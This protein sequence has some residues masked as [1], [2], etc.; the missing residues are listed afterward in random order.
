VIPAT[1]P[2]AV[3]VDTAH[4]V[5]TVRPLRA[6]GTAVDSDPRGK[7]PLL[8]DPAH[9]KLML[10]T[11]L[12]TLTYRL[13]TELSIQDWHWNP[14]GTFSDAA[15]GQGYWTS[16]PDTHAPSITDSF[17][18]TLPHRGDSRDQGDD[19]G[20]SRIDDGDPST[21]WKSNPYLTHRY[22]G[23][24]DSANPQ[25]LAVQ[26]L[27]PREIDAVRIAWSNPY[28]VRYDVQYWTG[29]PDAIL[30]PAAG[31]WHEFARGRISSGSGGTVTLRLANAPVRTTFVRVLMSASSNTCDTHGSGDVRNCLGYAVQDVGVGTI[32]AAGTFHNDVHESRDGSCNGQLICTPDPKRQ[33]LIW[34][35]SDDP[36]HRA[37]DKV[38]GDQDQTGLDL[39]ADSQLTRNLPAIYPVP[40]FY[41]TPQ[42]AANEIRY[43]EARGHKI[44]YVEMGEEV[45]GQYA[46]PEDYGA[47]YVQFAD[48]IHAVDPHVKL[49]GPVFEGVDADVRAWADRQ[50]RTSWLQRFIAY[51]KRRGRF[52][53][54]AFMSWEH[55]PYHHCDSGAQLQHDLLDEPDFV[56]R[57]VQTWRRDAATMPLLE[58]EDNFSPDGTAA[59]QHEY[60]PLWLG[61]FFGASLDSG[62]TY[63]TYYQAEA[64]PLGY[65][66]RCNVWGAY[67][68]Y[69]VDNQFRVRGKAP[70][71]YALR[72]LTTQW[73]QPGDE[74]QGVYPVTTSLGEKNAVLTA[75]ALHRPDGA[76]SLLVDN[77]DFVAHRVSVSIGASGF[78]GDV[79]MVS[80][81]GTKT[82]PA[83]ASY[84]VPAR[85]LT[86]LRGF[87]PVALHVD[88]VHPVQSLRPWD[89][90]GSTV[91]KEP[92]GSIPFLY[93]RA[94]VAQMLDAG[95]GFLSYRLFT[96]LTDED[97]HWNPSGSFSNGTDGYWTSSASPGQSAIAD[98]FGYRLPLTGNTTD[99]GASE[100]YSRLD[101]GD[102]Q[103]YW[104]SN[105]YLSSRF[106]GE[107]DE[108]HPQ[109]AVID[110]GK[111]T[112]V[113]AVRVTWVNPYAVDYDV[114]YWT[115]A[116][117]IGDP[118]HG[119]WRTFTGGSVRSAQG[120]EVTTRLEPTPRSVQFVRVL[121]T[122]SSNTCDTHASTD[123]R[124]CVGYAIGELAVGT[125]D[126]TGFHDV[127][128]H[129]AGNGQTVTYVS[130]VDPWHRASDRVRNQEQPGLDLIAQSGLTRNIGAF[131]PIPLWYSTPQNAANE[132]RYLRA[133]HYPIAGIEMGEEIDGQYAQPEDYAALYIEY[134]K[135]LRAVDPTVALGG[136]V[137]QG[138]N[139]DTKWWPDAHG[140][141]SWL[142]RFLGYLRTHDAMHYLNFMSFEHYPFGGCEHGAALQH[143][144][145]IEPSIVDTVVHAWRADGLPATVPMYVTEAGFSAVNFT[146]I[147]MQIQ[148][149]LWQADYMGTFLTDGVK[150]VV[151]YQY[152]PVP[153]SAN[154]KCDGD[155]GNLTMFVAG[156]HG[157]I[158]V[159]GAQF[160][161]S[162][163]LTQQWLQPGEATHEL[164]RV[165][166]SDGL[167]TA[168]AV[169][170]PDGS[171]S[172]LVDNK[173]RCARTVTLNLPLHGTVGVATFGAQQYRWVRAGA[174]SRPY[175]SRGILKYSVKAGSSYV[176]PPLSLTVLSGRVR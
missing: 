128:H 95:L 143:D 38:R 33:T 51:L 137:F 58:T 122:R 163:M 154:T 9:V 147:P 4:R 160:Y 14:R 150:R 90:I 93:T 175:P 101:D 13:Y 164:Y 92:A 103:T 174:N 131:Y 148:G 112:P 20:Y 2:I 116:D 63:A 6:M 81:H 1:A 110:L 64:E 89:A 37:S 16:S 144:L 169:K 45:D 153:L 155:W 80:L 3:R 25:W 167:V 18:Y 19:D 29:N 26:F 73:A 111:S 156:T 99:Q 44:A 140:D 62:V 46:T 49:G 11:G 162:Q 166:S 69:L 41:S 126:A 108:L 145:L 85:S 102:P 170:R 74:P 77:K 28:A 39:I 23:E 57:M 43:M 70:A 72:L 138:T 67:N 133:R 173:S 165:T 12:G 56:R 79:T 15:G 139:D 68:P 35:S 10:S 65:D 107:A 7:S 61:D 161:A 100:S 21:Y 94:N 71:Y 76:W 152:E 132:L 30:H 127:M 27:R 146:A 34:T 52:G 55:Y 97:W 109:W 151:Y 78:A 60:G 157:D 83:A 104:K 8:Y 130:S 66:K 141:T 105:P 48:A 40:V 159:R 158:H 24:S 136:P 123:P 91:D 87:A 86:V 129:A 53:D 125:L 119:S 168:Y 106:T 32:D 121:M 54:L 42:N 115:G 98:S 47:L 59:P 82:V 22:T 114:Q 117:A 113:D 149:A 124:N 88:T 36:W 176:V 5:Q 17:G 50:G 75:Y 31:S 135:A 120:A 172:V 142:H 96:E 84:E 118:E 171:W 134:A